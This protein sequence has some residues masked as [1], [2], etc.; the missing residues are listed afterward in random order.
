MR[1]DEGARHQIPGSRSEL[2]TRLGGEVLGRLLWKSQPQQGPLHRVTPA[3]ETGGVRG[4]KKAPKKKETGGDERKY[5][6]K[7]RRNN[8]Y[9]YGTNAEMSVLGDTAPSRGLVTRATGVESSR[10]LNS[11]PP[12]IKE[13]QSRHLELF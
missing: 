2:G 10:G 5:A 11:F 3:V 6:G 12:N 13:A 8:S 9:A 7:T 4:K 1:E